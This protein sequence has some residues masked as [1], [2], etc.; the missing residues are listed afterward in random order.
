M[1]IRR[2]HLYSKCY[3]HSHNGSRKTLTHNPRGRGR[4]W[5]LFRESRWFPFLKSH[6]FFHPAG[7]HPTC[8]FGNSI[9]TVSI[10]GK[11]KNS[12]TTKH[13]CWTS[14]QRCVF[15]LAGIK[16]WHASCLL[17]KN[18]GF[19]LVLIL[20]GQDFILSTKLGGGVWPPSD[21]HETHWSITVVLLIFP[22]TQWYYCKRHWGATNACTTSR[23]HI[24]F[25]ALSPPFPIQ[26]LFFPFIFKRVDRCE[27]LKL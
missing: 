21:T 10:D 3:T 26:L 8:V 19:V 23:F 16:A 4:N 24:F 9:K 1:R 17:A 15:L 12:C 27:P 6:H 2:R 25:L 14:K 11:Q 22:Q 5:R 20:Q 18:L 7:A 13:T